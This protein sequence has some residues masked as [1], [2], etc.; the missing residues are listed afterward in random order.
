MNHAKVWVDVSKDL[1]RLLLLFFIRI[2]V[3][4]VRELS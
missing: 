2:K 4:E 3:S 1:R